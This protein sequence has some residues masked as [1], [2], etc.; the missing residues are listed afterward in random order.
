MNKIIYILSLLVF[1]FFAASCSLEDE[2]VIILP[3]EIT[4]NLTVTIRVPGVKEHQ[5]QTRATAAPESNIATLKLFVYNK[6]DG[7]LA[8]IVNASGIS[9]LNT[10]GDGATSNALFTFVLE[11]YTSNVAQTAVFFANL[12][13]DA[14][15][16]LQNNPNIS[17]VSAVT[18][19]QAA[20]SAT[21][22]AL[23]PMWGMVELPT[24]FGDGTKS[25]FASPINL[26]RAVSKMTLKLNQE[27]LDNGYVLEEVVLGSR[28]STGYVQP[29]STATLLDPGG[30]II[31]KDNYNPYLGTPD[32]T[33]MQQGL[34]ET[35]ADFSAFVF[36]HHNSTAPTAEKTYLM[37]KIKAPGSTVSKFYRVDLYGLGSS[38]VGTD[39]E[40]HYL[41]LYRN[42]HYIIT[43]NSIMPNSGYDSYAQARKFPGSN[44]LITDVLDIDVSITNIVSNGQVYL[45][46]SDT[47]YTY[48]GQ[49][50]LITLGTVDTNLEGALASAFTVTS[51]ASW[52]S[53]LQVVKEG[54]QFL[55][56]GMINRDG[57]ETTR[58]T[59][60]VVSLTEMPDMNRMIHLVDQLNTFDIPETNF[61]SYRSDFKTYLQVR[62]TLPLY[63]N[64]LISENLQIVPSTSDIVF[65]QSTSFPGSDI[66]RFHTL[67]VNALEDRYDPLNNTLLGTLTLSY[68]GFVSKT[69]DI[70]QAHFIDGIS[71]TRTGSAV[72]TYKNGIIAIYRDNTDGVTY[73]VA[74]EGIYGG[75]TIESE[76]SWI[77]ING[78]GNAIIPGS[79]TP[80]ISGNELSETG[81]MSF[82]YRLEPQDIT[83]PDRYGRILLHYNNNQATHIIYVHQ[84][85]NDVTFGFSGNT[86]WAAR[87]SVKG[88]KNDK[89][90][91]LFDLIN[92]FGSRYKYG[93]REGGA[94]YEL[95]GIRYTVGKTE[96]A[97]SA[98]GMIPENNLNQ[99]QK[100]KDWSDWN[101]DYPPG[102]EPCPDGYRLPT[103][104]EIT[105]L[106]S[107][108]AP[109]NYWAKNY[110]N[111]KLR[112]IW[113]RINTNIAGSNDSNIDFGRGGMLYIDETNPKE[114]VTLYLPGGGFVFDDGSDMK[115]SRPF[116]F[117]YYYSGTNS[118]FPYS[119][120]DPYR[121]EGAYYWSSGG[122]T[123]EEQQIL[124][125]YHLPNHNVGAEIFR[126]GD[127]ATVLEPNIT[128]DEPLDW[129]H[130][131]SVRCV[132]K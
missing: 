93:S 64:T 92:D 100:D 71:E 52:L 63:D 48:G 68:P 19:S 13:A 15:T 97:Q 83:A 87:N 30:N 90:P 79:T 34:W 6:S 21:N 108:T 114:P 51:T 127:R 59:D 61:V 116:S 131:F 110:G 14:H 117:R 55:V 12:S 1:L 96:N 33:I 88:G 3:D 125:I 47:K 129:Y 94:T 62:T 118:I 20:E 56:K 111:E 115:D 36:E 113:G 2:I 75:W 29:K 85:F 128:R 7:A 35:T 122:N 49:E 103:S 121:N 50:G 91:P 67:E 9:H 119:T 66:N 39:V 105:L 38:E 43:I 17:A 23:L 44:I 65:S 101:T 57:M 70:R 107:R 123:R 10:S 4:G 78:R 60:L 16:Y 45:G 26:Y 8:K 106:R 69:I 54:D 27:L 84:G 102:A 25:P 120:F 82:T 132:R 109:V 46:V 18:M 76:K 89:E 24:G 95:S 5:I 77:Q 37:A 99:L 98:S 40:P 42:H 31:S 73:D 86:R 22:A 53:E 32:E 104:S 112:A 81:K 11:A 130:R 58:E 72:G 74:V 28:N 41:N 124:D 126:Y 80:Y